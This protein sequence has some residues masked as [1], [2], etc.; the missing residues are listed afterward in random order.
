M[1]A[2]GSK[3]PARGRN[4]PATGSNRPAGESRIPAAGRKVLATGRRSPACGSRAPA[5]GS[6]RP[7]GESKRPAQGRS[8]P[9]QESKSP[10]HGSRQTASG[11]K[12]PACGRCIIINNLDSIKARK[13]AKSFSRNKILTHGFNRGAH[14]TSSS[15]CSARHPEEGINRHLQCQYCIRYTEKPTSAKFGRATLCPVIQ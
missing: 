10:A 15:G 2:A 8:I 9:V 7:A 13:G 6:R 5:T 12:E 3:S 1:H 4:V 14:R 11:S